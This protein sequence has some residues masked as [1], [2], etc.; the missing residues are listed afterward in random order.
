MNYDLPWNPQRIEQRIGRCHRYGQDYDVVVV[1][2]LNKKN[3]ADQRVYEL[4]AEKFQLFSG[5][6]GASDEVL[7]TI[8]SGVDFEKRIVAIY[9]TC[10]TPEQIEAAFAQLRAEM[11]EKITVTMQ[12]TRQKLLENFDA[13]VHDRLRVNLDQSLEYLNRYER[14]LW[15]VT[16]YELENHARFD[17]ETL[18]FTLA[19][20]PDGVQAEPGFYRFSKQDERGHRYRLG[21]PLAQHLLEQAAIRKLQGAHLKLDYGAWPQKALSLEPLIGRQGTLAALKLSISGADAQDHILVAAITEDGT[22]LD[23]RTAFRL[24]ELP[25]SLAHTEEIQV[26]DALRNMLRLQQQAV[27]DEMALCQSAWFDEAMEK[28]DAWADDKRASLK[29]NLKE[30]DEQARTLKKEIRRTANLPE[31]LALQRRV[32]SLETRRDE[33]W[34]VYDDA[35]REIEIEKERLLDA[36]ESNLKQAVNT[37]PLFTVTFE[38]C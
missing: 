6:F 20:A 12:D 14:M 18:S 22:E 4:L 24:F 33:A 3:E 31:K 2:F 13:E 25:A 38:V 10:R 21:H 19:R 1:N 11:D 34:R 35:A 27:L 9:Q 29:I 32:K 15:A 8:E 30:L 37:G 26:P 7:G 23:Q 17:D 28:L 36:V 16:R 5:V